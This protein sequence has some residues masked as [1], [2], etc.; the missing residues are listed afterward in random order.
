MHAPYT[1]IRGHYNTYR[2]FAQITARGYGSGMSDIGQKIAK[3]RS[4][5]SPPNLPSS[6]PITHSF[7]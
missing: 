6:K 1:T 2:G 3:A 4:D 7:I 5:Q